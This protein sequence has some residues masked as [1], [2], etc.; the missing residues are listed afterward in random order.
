MDKVKHYV[1]KNLADPSSRQVIALVSLL[2]FLLGV[3]VTAVLSREITTQS[4]SEY[5][6][7]LEARVGNLGAQIEVKDKNYNRLLVASASRYAHDDTP[8]T[9]GDFLFPREAGAVHRAYLVCSYE[10]GPPERC[11]PRPAPCHGACGGGCDGG[12]C[13]GPGGGARHRAR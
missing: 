6:S 8:V 7:D 4:E 2:V 5:I 3:G 12:A 1:G 10:A 9:I 11:L 13:G